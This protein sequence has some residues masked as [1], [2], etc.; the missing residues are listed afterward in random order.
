MPAIN[1]AA[2]EAYGL[3]RAQFPDRPV[4]VAAESIGCGPASFLATSPHPPE[5][6]ALILPYD[7]LA[8]VAARHYRFLPVKLLL[9]D[10]WDNIAALKG[11]EGQLELFAARSDSII[12]VSHAVSLAGSKPSAILH[13][14]EGD[15]NDW[16]DGN[17]VKIRYVAA[18]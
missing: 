12:P 6:I 4:C 15:H 18:K 16:A 10:N 13:I 5:K 2:R 9:R 14:I 1:G 3:L 17:K 8:A 7:N 11:Y